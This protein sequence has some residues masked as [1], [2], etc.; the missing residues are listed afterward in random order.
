MQT[1]LEETLDCL[2]E[3]HEDLASLTLILPSKRA[4]GFLKHYLRKKVRT[5]T[6]APTVISIEEF[7]ETLSDLK[8]IDTTELLFRSFEAYLQIDT[9]SEKENFESFT[10]W[11]TTLLNDFNEIDRYLVDPTPFFSY[12]GSIKSLEKWNVDK[13]KTPLIEAY[14]KFWEQ[15]PYFY[16]SLT[17][18]LLQDGIGYQGLVY[19]KA[20]EDIEFYLSKHGLKPHIFIGFNA[21]NTA[22][23]QIIQALLA[24][25]PS[26]IYWDADRVFMDNEKHSASLFL[27]RYKASWNYYK[28]N[29]FTSIQDNF[30]SSKEIHIVEAQR[31]MGQ[32]KYVASVLEK[33]SEEELSKTAIVLADESLLLPVLHS[34]PPSIHSVNV[35]M[36]APLRSFPAA[37]FFD[38]LLLLHSKPLNTLYFK[39]VISIIQD[40]LVNKLISEP[41][42]IIQQIV[43]SNLTHFSL[44]RLKSFAREDDDSV[45]DSLF[46]DWKNLS[47]TAIHMCLSLIDIIK[48][49]EDTNRLDRI[50]LFHIHTVFTKISALNTTFPHLKSCKT[51]HRLFNELIATTSLDFEGDAYKGLQIMGVLETRVLDFE[52]I[53]MLSVNEG[54]IPSG[55][56]NAS[57][58][59]YDLK[60]QFNLPLY[61]EKDAIYT[62]H[63]YR[64]LHR[65]QH[66]TLLYNSYSDGLSLGEK[67]RFLLQLDIEKQ[68]QHT[69]TKSSISPMVKTTPKSPITMTKTP[70]VIERIQAIA[71]KGF[72]PSALASYVRNPLDFYYQKVLGV[73]EFLE[74]EETVAANTLGTIVHDTLQELYGPF[75]GQL[76]TIDSLNQAKEN[77]DS[78][79][80][81]Q[82]KKTFKE[83]DFSSGKNLIIFEVAKRYIHN[84]IGLEISEIKNGHRIKLVAVENDL[85]VP[86]TV[87][88]L[89]FPI[90]IGGK[91]DRVDEYDGTLR[92]V[93]YKTGLVRQGELEVSDWEVITTDYKYS[94]ALQV[95]SYA[96]MLNGDTP[97]TK[98]T[99]GIISFKNLGSGFLPFATKPSPRSQ[100]K[101]VL[102]T[103]DVLHAYTEEL[104]KLIME[105][106][107]PNIPFT[108]KEIDPYVY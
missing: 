83:G 46:G 84:F 100:Q 53:I 4:G 101:D 61:T 58:I 28:T 18:Q 36:G 73:H 26:E 8:I 95:L 75:I 88:G 5:T 89:E 47:N 24:Q 96:L 104:N 78:E 31:N 59:T 65:A 33:F 71:G 57:F 1:F 35:T 62:Y 86:I 20:A 29:E 6:F 60:K 12:L 21:L 74:I 94:K 108:E 43:Q 48:D 69:I 9:A 13:E 107:D 93:D 102:I 81:L 106:C 42:E 68:P 51:V 44:E 40:P 23:Q 22:E 56:S 32:V 52:R 15:L 55:K 37:L 80:K 39:D 30:K 87:P 63:F 91:V 14:L 70:E 67:S 64:L 16:E 50:V 72:S 19:R 11:A 3:K 77:I 2:I 90:Y 10:S 27:R 38:S 97:I 82:F 99:A 105:I 7:I 92:I 98:A 49:S 54:I 85:R 41:R 66:I 17:H 34:L 103:Q 45:L 25:G 76:L 79:V